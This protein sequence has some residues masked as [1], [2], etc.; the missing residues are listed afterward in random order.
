[1]LSLS[2]YFTP[3]TVPTPVNRVL[4]VMR[5]WMTLSE[6]VEKEYSGAS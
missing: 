4:D 1:V 2:V 3:E 6:L 5:W